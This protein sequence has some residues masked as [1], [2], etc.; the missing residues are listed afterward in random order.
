MNDLIWHSTGVHLEVVVDVKIRPAEHMP[1]RYLD[2]MAATG[3]VGGVG[4]TLASIVSASPWA[5]AV[6]AVGASLFVCAG[7]LARRHQGLPREGAPIIWTR[8]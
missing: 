2:M 7:Y 6:A 4:G 8:L 1:S 3:L 5:T